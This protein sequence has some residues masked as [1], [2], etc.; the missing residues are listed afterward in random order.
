MTK[1]F[2]MLEDTRCKGAK[3]TGKKRGLDTNS[4]NV[5]N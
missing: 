5:N 1:K 3:Q 4:R 2:N